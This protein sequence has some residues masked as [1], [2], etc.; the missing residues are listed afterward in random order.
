MSGFDWPAVCRLGLLGLR[1]APDDFWGATP[2]ELMVAAGLT[3]V[4]GAV[5]DRDWFDALSA[6]FPDD[7]MERAHG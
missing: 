5:T 2:G 4:Q 6:R 3:P 1:M 7:V